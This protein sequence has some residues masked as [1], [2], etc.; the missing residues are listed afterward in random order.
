[1]LC[2]GK[3]NFLDF[4]N[5]GLERIAGGETL[6]NPCDNGELNSLTMEPLM[7]TRP[8]SLQLRFAPFEKGQSGAAVSGKKV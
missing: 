7:G 3:V 8:W 5:L 6:V 1:M 4:H 2:A